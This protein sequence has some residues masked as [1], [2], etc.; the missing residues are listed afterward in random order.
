MHNETMEPSR[1]FQAPGQ[2]RCQQKDSLQSL[3][4]Q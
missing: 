4:R 3:V 1:K 2:L